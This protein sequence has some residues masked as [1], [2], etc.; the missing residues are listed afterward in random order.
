MNVSKIRSTFRKLRGQKPSRIAESRRSRPELTAL[1][2][3]IVMSARWGLWA[4][5]V[6]ASGVKSTASEVSVVTPVLANGILVVR[7]TN[8]SDT[9]DVTLSGS[10]IKVAGKSFAANSVNK[11]VVVGEKG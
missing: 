2:G 8:N 9:I 5:G 11:I 3:R 6:A 4:G 1:E 7:G 10:N